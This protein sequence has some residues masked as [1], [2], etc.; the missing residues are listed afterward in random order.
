MGKRKSRCSEEAVEVIQTPAIKDVVVATERQEVEEQELF[1]STSIRKRH[2]KRKK[3][4]STSEE[5]VEAIKT[6][7][8][9]DVVLVT[10]REEEED[11]EKVFTS[12]SIR[13]QHK[14]KR[15]KTEFKE[16]AR[17]RSSDRQW[18]FSSHDSSHLKDKVIIVSYNILGVANAAN[19]PDLYRNVS[20]KFLDWNRR[21]KLIRNELN[22]YTPSII[23]FQEVDRFSDLNHLMKLDGFE[24]VYKARTGDAQDGCAIF[25]KKELFTIMQQDDIEFRMFDMRENVAQFCVLKM[26][27]SNSND[28][29]HAHLSQT[30]PTR[31][32]LVGNIHGLFN[33]SRG[34]IKLGQIRLYIEKASTLSQ[35]WGIIPVVLAGDFN[36]MPQSAIYQFL[37]SSELDIQLHDRRNMAGQIDNSLRWKT[38]RSHW[39]YG[40]SWQM[41]IST[42]LRFSWS[43]QELEIAAG[44][45]KATCLQHSLKLSSAYVGVPGTS[46]TRD[47]HGEPL[48]TS[49]HSKFKGT[50]DYIWHT[51]DLVP[52]GI[53]ETLPDNI[54]RQTR[55]LPGE[56]WGSDHLAVVCE[57]AFKDNDHET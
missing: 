39:T 30:T 8:I 55:G 21:K 19:H 22:E 11:E 47:K 16:D 13:K 51:E 4:S 54:L 24:G 34:D 31:Y 28:D 20:P 38:A 5:A 15:R 37:A 10:E 27:T 29:V 53:L 6:P 43:E 25:W 50:V 56:K 3:Y 41:P 1:T 42:P 36:S 18:V 26:N 45:G 46:S 44:S 32:L 2:K 23:C 52:V 48:A 35:E 40:N 9:K 14:K 12:T 33:P 17:S 57:L 7:S 49:Y